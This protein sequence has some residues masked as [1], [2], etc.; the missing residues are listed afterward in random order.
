MQPHYGSD[1]IGDPALQGSDIEEGFGPPND[2]AMN[3]ALLTDEKALEEQ[4]EEL[5]ADA[6]KPAK[7][8]RSRTVSTIVTSSGTS[9][10]SAGT[11]VGNDV[12]S[13]YLRSPT[14]RGTAPRPP[15]RVAFAD[16]ARQQATSPVT[17]YGP[18]E[19]Q[20]RVEQARRSRRM[21]L[22]APAIGEMPNAHDTQAGGG[23]NIR[24]QD[25][26]ASVIP[27]EDEEE[28]VAAAVALPAYRVPR[29]GF[30]HRAQEWKKLQKLA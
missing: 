29:D 9:A 3:G 5:A 24:S 11:G 19:Q 25:P 21:S 4:Q 30:A 26:M 22:T 20:R 18:L 27:E 13:Y 8:H 14:V 15:A 10:Y 2:G 17:L 7:R 23:F 12:D 1:A 16:S 6:G 28:N